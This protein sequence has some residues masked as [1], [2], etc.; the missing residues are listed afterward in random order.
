MKLFR[1]KLKR[2]R[3]GEEGLVVDLTGEEEGEVEVKREDGEEKGKGKESERGE[4]GFSVF[5]DDDIW[6]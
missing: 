6:A 5:F 4:R 2:E 1:G 3:I